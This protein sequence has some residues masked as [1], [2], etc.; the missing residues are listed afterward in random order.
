MGKIYQALEKSNINNPETGLE[1]E[2]EQD[3]HA[4]RNHVSQD[5]VS[6]NHAAPVD[7]DTPAG[8]H[9]PAVTKTPAPRGQDDQGG[10]QDRT[11]EK[12][13]D[14]P[15]N[16]ASLKSFDDP[17]LV[18]PDTV[19]KSLVTVFTPHSIESE[20]FRMLKNNI[21]FPEKGTPPKTIMVT[22]P[23]PGEGKT[24]VAANLA[25]T[26]AQNIDEYVLLIDCDLR[27][28]YVHKVFGLTDPPG[29]SEYLSQA[30]PL[31]SLLVKTFLEKLTILPSGAIPRNPSELLSSEQMRRLLTEVKTRYSDRYV[32]IDT[33]PPYLTSETNALARH[34]D[35]IIL[36]VR[37]GKTRK[38]EI[39]NILDIYGKEKIIGVVQ[40]FA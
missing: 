5:R 31:S 16:A 6:R 21:L 30:R 10:H 25:A 12:P 19:D 24:F 15:P 14:K 39:Q 35:G 1:Q 32:I 36:V 29:L 26:I 11:R 4:S 7:H 2:Q 27:S 13:A 8:R 37:Q 28:P 33:P 40:N 34:V 18:I 9:Q 23:S 3:R 17:D 38:K 20:Q 22:S